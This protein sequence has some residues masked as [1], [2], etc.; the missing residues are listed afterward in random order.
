MPGVY[1]VSTERNKEKYI[2]SI[3][4]E[5]KVLLCPSDVPI[6]LGGFEKN[7]GDNMIFQ[8]HLLHPLHPNCGI[9][10]VSKKPLLC[11][12]SP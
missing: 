3:F 6:H 7:R 4:L 10:H 9:S 8:V 1:V 12:L 2:Y 11:L 5:L